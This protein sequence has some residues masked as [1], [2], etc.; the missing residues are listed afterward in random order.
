[1]TCCVSMT[2]ACTHAYP[3]SA[4]ADMHLF[5]I[6]HTNT[7]VGG[8]VVVYKIDVAAKR[9]KTTTEN[10][11]HKEKGKSLSRFRSP[12]K[13]EWHLDSTRDLAKTTR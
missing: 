5:R 13:P 3:C 6:Y 2:H 8:P 12:T 10:E 9:P 4:E 7:W 1:M 11:I